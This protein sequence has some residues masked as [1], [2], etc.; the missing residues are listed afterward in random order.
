MA[1]LSIATPNP[2]WIMLHFQSYFNPQQGRTVQGSIPIVGK[3]FSLLHTQADQ[4]C[5]ALHPSLQWV[6]GCGTDHQPPPPP[7]SNAEVK[8]KDS[9]TS[10]PPSVPSMACYWVTFTFTFTFY[11]KIKAMLCVQKKHATGSHPGLDK[12]DA[13]PHTLFL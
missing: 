3:M 12:P 4:P 5:G 10:T 8:N 2:S 1:G 11:F 6:Q 13:N 7:P 9:Y